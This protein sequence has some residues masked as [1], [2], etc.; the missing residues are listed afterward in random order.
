MKTKPDIIERARIFAREAHEGVGHKRRYTGEDYF[1]HLDAVARLVASV[2]DDPATIAAA[3]LHDIVEDTPVTFHEIA[4]AFGADIAS[5]V[6]YLTDI[7]RPKD[8]NRAERKA[9]DRAHTGRGDARVHTIKLADLI[10]NSLSVI[11]HDTKFAVV[12]MNE[13]RA[14]LPYLADG[15][16][17]LLARATAIVDA[18]FEGTDA[19]A[20]GRASDDLSARAGSGN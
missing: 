12:Y 18:W 8:G 1:V 9:I 16:P 15:H 7:S 4:E 10:D 13:K 19:R 17:A 14:L 6:I 5:L 20:A 2:V 3:Y 11:R